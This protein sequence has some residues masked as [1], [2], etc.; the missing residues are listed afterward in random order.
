MEA[1]RVAVTSTE[2]HAWSLARYI[3]GFFP[4]G[5]LLPSARGAT[6]CWMLEDKCT[7]PEF[8]KL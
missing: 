4:A 5:V 3:E 6:P 7:R 2:A 1:G 8:E